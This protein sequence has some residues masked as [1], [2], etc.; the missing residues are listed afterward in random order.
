MEL[1]IN[2]ISDKNIKITFYPSQI[3]LI[4][5]KKQEKIHFEI[6]VIAIP[7]SFP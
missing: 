5:V 1:N 2:V 4:E 3:K 7:F 6:E